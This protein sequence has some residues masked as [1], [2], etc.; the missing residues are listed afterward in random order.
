MDLW[1]EEGI[2]FPEFYLWNG[3]KKR[4]SILKN[5]QIQCLWQ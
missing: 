3:K 4:G 1:Y 2:D 5:H